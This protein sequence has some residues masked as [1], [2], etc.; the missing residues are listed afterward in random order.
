MVDPRRSPRLLSALMSAVLALTLAACSGSSSGENEAA[1]PG[2]PNVAV[3]D[4]WSTFE[5]A[6]FS[7]QYP[8][9]FEAI[10][11]LLSDSAEGYDSVVFEAPDGSA[12]FYVLA[13]QWG[14]AAKDIALDRTAETETGR[15]ERRSGD[16]MQINR[17]IRANDGS[18]TRE[19]E[20]NRE[21]DGLVQWVF[22]F[23]YEDEVAHERYAPDFERFRSSL[24]TFT[25]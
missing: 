18:Y 22:Q 17:T 21:Q 14:R 4:A 9:S 2:T 23:R 16:R 11:S 20:V 19:I 10:P 3:I 1:D 6:W 12:A 8:A 5:G 13:P 25:D 15:D 24:Q 7:I